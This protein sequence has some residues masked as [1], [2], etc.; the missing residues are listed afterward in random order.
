[1]YHISR[2]S[3]SNNRRYGVRYD[4]IGAEIQNGI[5]W[6]ICRDV[7]QNIRNFK[8]TQLQS[9]RNPNFKWRLELESK[10]IVRFAEISDVFEKTVVV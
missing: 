7:D 4:V 5:C 2:I 9:E 1:M 8:L 10:P 3:T 6:F